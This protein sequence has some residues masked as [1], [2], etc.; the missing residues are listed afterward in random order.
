MI[1]RVVN[2]VHLIGLWSSEQERLGL[3]LSLVL[4]KPVSEP[5]TVD[6]NICTLT[7][8]NYSYRT[9]LQ[10]NIIHTV[11]SSCIALTV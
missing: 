7:T 10:Q 1:L 3:C 5:G 2:T 4:G 11:D 6:E 9:G 8:A